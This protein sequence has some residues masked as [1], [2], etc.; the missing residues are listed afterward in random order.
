MKRKIYALRRIGVRNVAIAYLL[1]R[2]TGTPSV[3]MLAHHI[4]FSLSSIRFGLMVGVAG[5]APSAEKDIRRG[6]I[7]LQKHYS[8]KSGHQ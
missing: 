3:K 5:G 2:L 7:F 8:S 4:R 6:V 1:S